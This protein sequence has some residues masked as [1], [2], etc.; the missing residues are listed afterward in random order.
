MSILNHGL[1]AV[2]LAQKSMPADMEAE[3]SK[4]NTIKIL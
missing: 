2:A 4:C 1:Q 3:A